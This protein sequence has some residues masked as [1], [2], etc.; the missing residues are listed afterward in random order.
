MDKY[1]SIHV[2]PSGSDK[3]DGAVGAP[4]KTLGRALELTRLAGG[5]GVICLK[6][7]IYENT[8][9]ALDGRDNGL[10]IRAECAGAGDSVSAGAGE[11]GGTG[12]GVGSGVRAGDNGD[13][14]AGVGYGMGTGVGSGT[15]AAGGTGAGGAVLCGGIRVSGWKKQ[16]DGTYRAN[17]PETVGSGIRMIAVNGHLRERARVPRVGRLT[18]RSE[19][20][21]Q[22]LSSSDGGWAV[23]PTEEQ[24]TTMKYDPADI[25]PDFDWQNAE[26]TIFHKWDDSMAGIAAHDREGCAFRLS[27][28]L[29]HPPGAYGYNTYIIWNTGAGM[30][31]GMWRLD[32]CERAVYYMPLDGEDMERAEVYMPV[33]DAIITI[34]GPMS[35]LTIEDVGFTVTSTPSTACGFGASHM[36]GAID[37]THSLECCSFKN[38]AFFA[39]SGWGIRLIDS[40][41]TGFTEFAEDKTKIVRPDGNRNVTVDG[42]AVADVGAGGIQFWGSAGCEVKNSTV[43][44][45][46]RI[47]YSAI[48]IYTFGCDLIGNVLR[49]LPYTGI[50]SVGGKSVN[51]TG[52]KM[53]EVMKELNDGAGIY[54]TFSKNGR[55]ST[56]AVYGIMTQDND[57]P[58]SIRNGLYLD[59]QTGGWVVEGNLTSGCASGMLNH[60][61]KGNIVRNNA[62]VS[63]DGGVML[64]FVRCEGYIFE[65]NAIQAS[66]NV[67]IVQRRDAFSTF[68]GNSIYSGTGVVESEYIGD[69]YKRNRQPT[70]NPFPD[71]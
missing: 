8:S 48:G 4:V 42:C 49:E 15:G 63:Q 50:A 36:T 32:K 54:A 2:S 13:A 10:T 38:L 26:L 12:A 56:N 64:T 53:Y 17:L 70:F 30:G 51:I 18:H 11:S 29:T 33:H 60:M 47:Y 27:T 19:F 40:N 28:P 5:G 69:D 61:S 3:N 6:S 25:G 21:S 68:S 31:P 67:L 62:F 16:G 58:G 65:N 35:G 37:C 41:R 59:E 1:D 55:M 34:A 45:A 24:L 7:G 57:D 22:W 46:G 44:R 52:N 20:T 66:G 14:E 9:V 23:K 39:L 43:E 71:R